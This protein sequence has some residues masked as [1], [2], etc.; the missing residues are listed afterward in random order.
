MKTSKSSAS[1]GGPK[2]RG[3]TA[4]TTPP[5]KIGTQPHVARDNQVEPSR[6]V[7]TGDAVHRG[8][9][10]DT[11]KMYTN[12]TRHSARGNTPRADVT[13]RKR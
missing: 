13:T 12:N 8:A 11:S 1:A 4:K 6:P 9:R 10:R 3:R 2:A 7:G 5:D